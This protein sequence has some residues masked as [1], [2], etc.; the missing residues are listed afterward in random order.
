MTSPALGKSRGS[1]R[2]LL[3][4]NHPVS[5]L[6][7]RAGAPVNP[8]GSSPYWASS[9]CGGG[10]YPMTSFTLS[11]ARGSVRLLLTKNHPVLSPAFRVGAPVNPLGSPQLRKFLCLDVCPSTAL[12]LLNGFR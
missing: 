6:A 2:F 8:V 4:K 9:I 3:T 12:K 1:G 7:F 11:E 5:P 10:N